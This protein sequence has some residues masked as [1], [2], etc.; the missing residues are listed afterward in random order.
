MT[1][2]IE[3]WLPSYRSFIETFVVVLDISKAF[4]IVWKK[5]LVFKHRHMIYYLSFYTFISRVPYD[6]SIVTLLDD[7]FFSKPFDNGVPQGSVL[8][9]TLFILFINDLSQTQCLV[10]SSTDATNIHFTSCARRQSQ[11]KLNSQTNDTERQL[12]FNSWMGKAN[13]MMFNVSKT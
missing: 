5:S 12:L 1:F 3:S 10:Y 13:I 7:H 2:P 6:C 4:N 11:Q 9:P 8:S